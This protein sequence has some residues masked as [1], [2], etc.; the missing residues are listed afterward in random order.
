MA[1]LPHLLILAAMVAIAGCAVSLFGCPENQT[2]FEGGGC[3]DLN[4]NGQ[5]DAF[6]GTCEDGIR[7][8]DETGVDC[9]G[10]CTPCAA[11]GC[12]ASIDC[13]IDRTGPLYCDNDAIKQ[14]I[15]GYECVNAGE[16]GAHCTGKRHTRTWETCDGEDEYC[17]DGA[18]MCMTERLID[19]ACHNARR[20]PWEEGI[21]CGGPC[22]P[23]HNCANGIKDGLE[24]GID[25]G[26]PSCRPCPTCTDGIKNGQ[27]VGVD[28][29]GPVCAPCPSCTDGTMNGNERG[30]DC[31]GACPPCHPTCFNGV[32][33]GDEEGVDC[34]G[35]CT[36]CP[37]CNDGVRNGL[38]RGPDC[39]GPCKP[40]PYACYE[41]QDCG[42]DHQGID[43]CINNSVYHVYVA[44]TCE[45]AGTPNATCVTNKTHRF[46]EK[47]AD[48]FETCL[49]TDY[50]REFADCDDEV[51]EGRCILNS[52]L[53]LWIW[54]DEGESYRI[55]QEAYPNVQSPTTIIAAR[56]SPLA[57]R[58]Y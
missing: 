18:E 31:G 15:T 20:D 17:L 29:G 43:T 41:D 51:V 7:N 42:F 6:E 52:R 9:G 48:K 45:H 36:P 4:A 49:V 23:C 26:G 53:C 11:I 32:R 39:G 3:D 22:K 37:A 54:C 47:C 1:K 40:C 27:E 19:A 14:D 44:Y 58:N 5:C 38:E 33:D 56:S 57:D 21:D 12:R 24:D 35:P 34:G 10:P 50:C 30:I 13:G 46:E 55:R 2:S 8:R 28:C 25:C 16:P